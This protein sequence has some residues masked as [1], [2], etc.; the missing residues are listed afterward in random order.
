[1]VDYDATAD[2][3]EDNSIRSFTTDSN[4]I[5]SPVVVVDSTSSKKSVVLP[6]HIYSP[7]TTNSE[8]L[9]GIVDVIQNQE[10]KRWIKGLLYL[11]ML[12]ITW[13]ASIQLANDLMKDTDYDHPL[14]VASIDGGFFVL[15]GL[16]PF[17]ER[18][19]SKAELNRSEAAGSIDESGLRLSYTD[20][21]IVGAATSIVYFLSGACATTALKYTTTSNQTI[22]STTSS[23]F[24]LILGVMAKV[25]KFTVAKLISIIASISG[26]CLITL[27]G[28]D[29]ATNTEPAH[30]PIVGNLLA[31]VGAAAYSGFLVIMKWKLG[32]QVDSSRNSLVYTCLGICTFIFVTP[33]LGL[34][35]LFGIEKFALPGNNVIMGKILL[36]GFLNTVSDYCASVA[37]LLMSPLITSLSLS[38]AIPM[39]MI[40]DSVFFHTVPTSFSYY[41]GLVLIF[42]SFIFTSLSDKD[43]A[44]EDAVNDAVSEAVSH[45]KK[46][47]PF[48]TPSQ[49]PNS[50]NEDVPVMNIDSTLEEDPDTSSMSPLHLVITGGNNGRYF[51]RKV[52]NIL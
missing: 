5:G 6:S 39:S 42:A 21:L 28:T 19:R 50:T 20:I 37:A 32:E 11:F 26:I 17:L 35:D 3:S 47:T 27:T 38:T 29:E 2:S 48:F 12:V 44:V 8:A 52:E 49:L 40:C 46:L 13:V 31:V 41:I 7:L 36:C 4:P 1:M 34:A 16:Q 10:R 24:S 25:E 9:T 15:F 45:D 43:E 33:L 14:F 18:C 30:S 23:L 51:I 22:L